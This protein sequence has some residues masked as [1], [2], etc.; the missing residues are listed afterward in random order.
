MS[1]LFT[2]GEH[3]RRRAEKLGKMD[4]ELR[5]YRKRKPKNPFS[6]D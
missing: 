3:E 2:D 6:D 4:A 1:H 5:D